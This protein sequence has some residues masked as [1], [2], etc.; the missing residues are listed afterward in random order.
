MNKARRHEL[1][2]LRFKRRLKN[3]GIVDN[4]SINTNCFRTT[5]K[6]A[7]AISAVAD[8]IKLQAKRKNSFMRLIMS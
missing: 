3:R 6:P 5:G 2:M 7:H 4:A 1:K 8:P